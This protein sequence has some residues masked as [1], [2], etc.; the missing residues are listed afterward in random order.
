MLITSIAIMSVFIG[1][2]ALE[3]SAIITDAALQQVMN[4]CRH[5]TPRMPRK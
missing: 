2:I 4:H 3:K 1:Y 5:K